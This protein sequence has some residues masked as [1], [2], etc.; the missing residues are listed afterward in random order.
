MAS[1][2]RNLRLILKNDNPSV[3]FWINSQNLRHM[4]AFAANKFL[5]GSLFTGGTEEMARRGGEANRK[6]VSLVPLRE[7][8][9]QK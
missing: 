5:A 1:S 3:L 2:R 8:C 6:V 4:I 7:A 9:R